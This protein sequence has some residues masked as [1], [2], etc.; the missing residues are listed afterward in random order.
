MCR[1]CVVLVFVLSSQLGFSQDEYGIAHSNYAPT[2]TFLHNPTNTLDNKTYFDFNLI[3]AGV[4]VYNDYLFQKGTQF[5]FMKNI[6]LA[7]E[8]PDFQFNT[9]GNLKQGF[10]DA[11]VQ[12]ISG[13]FQY[14]EHGFAFGVRTRTYFDFRRVSTSVGKLIKDGT[15]RFEDY[16]GETL[17]T[18]KMFMNQTA[19]TDISVSYS[20]MFYHFAHKSMALGITAKYLMGITGAGVK[21]D[22]LEFNVSDPSTTDF[23][24]F[25]GSVAY[26][27]GDSGKLS[28]G[29]GFAVDLGYVYKKT[30]HNVTHYEPFSKS[31]ACENYDYKLKIAAAIIDLG[32]INFNKQA[33]R[34]DIETDPTQVALDANS[35][36]FDNFG[37]F[38]I[39]NFTN[40]TKTDEFRMLTPAALNIQVDYNLENNFFISGQYMH[41]FFRR[42]AFGVKRPHVLAMSGRY[43]RKWFEGSL[44]A[45]AYNYQ[46]FR[47]GLAIRF[48]YLTFG[49]DKLLSMFGIADFYGTDAYFNIRYFM[50]RKP[51]CK[52]RHKKGRNNA[53]DCVKN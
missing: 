29:S 53:T 2:K 15:G 7:E 9:N 43:Q 22:E 47:M 50:T 25:D 13:A 28:A 19:F 39:D 37:D 21:V 48:G 10:Q 18:K 5:S 26:G 32:L 3:G 36:T 40:I 41:G 11:D 45:S 14:K 30:L 17:N 46:D 27:V 33:S 49:T 4:F 16:Y 24:K 44:V 38:A 23:F 20:N 52:R 51:G 34:I 42:N 6:V 35:L 1:I 8:W 31:S 12:L